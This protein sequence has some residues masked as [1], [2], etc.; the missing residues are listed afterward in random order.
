MWH[1][2]AVWLFVLLF[3]PLGFQ[4]SELGL[5]IDNGR[6]G[7]RN[8][9]RRGGMAKA[10]EQMNNSLQTICISHF[11]IP[12]YFDRVTEGKSAIFPDDPAR[13]FKAKA[14]F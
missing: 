10:A 9:T 3:K 12:F 8:F 1:V 13:A 7:F 14:R 4:L 11:M 2:E 5:N 6:D